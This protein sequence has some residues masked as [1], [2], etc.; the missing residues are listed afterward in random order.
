VSAMTAASG[1]I[2]P[3]KS[4]STKRSCTAHASREESQEN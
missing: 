3:E 4:N 2:R 1:L